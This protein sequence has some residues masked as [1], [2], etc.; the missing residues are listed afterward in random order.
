MVILIILTA[1]FNHHLVGIPSHRLQGSECPLLLLPPNAPPCS[2]LSSLLYL[3]AVLHPLFSGVTV[4]F[5][6]CHPDLIFSPPLTLSFLHS[7][8]NNALTPCGPLVI[9][10]AP[11]LITLS[12][13]FSSQ[14]RSPMDQ[15]PPRISWTNRPSRHPCWEPS[16]DPDADAPLAAVKQE[17]K[18]G[19]D[20]GQGCRVTDYR[21]AAEAEVERAKEQELW[22]KRSRVK[23]S[24]M[25]TSHG[26]LMRREKGSL[27]EY[28]SQVKGK[29]LCTCTWLH[30]WVRLRRS[31]AWMY[32]AALHRNP[33]MQECQCSCIQ[34]HHVC[35]K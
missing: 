4:P 10:S 31:D 7:D 12:V 11:S 5:H 33:C 14:A 32:A 29:C 34:M 9:K 30:A 23:R 28:E 19:R 26:K 2:S 22:E 18:R 15:G 24:K 27:A 21:A 16:I 6:F 8:L 13:S 17:G 1:S 35:P 25:M 20:G 3:L